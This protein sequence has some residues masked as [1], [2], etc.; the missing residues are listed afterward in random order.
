MSNSDPPGRHYIM[1]GVEFTA[2]RPEP[3][4][5]VTATPIGHLGDVTLRALETLA[6]ADEILCEDTRVTAKLTSRY[7][8]RTPLR[9]YHDHNAAKLRPHIIERLKEGAAIAL[10]SDAGTPLVSDPGYKLIAAVIA[11]GLP[12]HVLPGA[13]APL[14]GLLQS[15]LPP[16][17]FMFLGFLPEKQGER[18]RRL[19][20]LKSADATLIVFESPHRIAGTLAD[21][22]AIMGTRAVAV[23]REL[24]KLHEEILRGPAADIGA[25][26]A[27]REAVKGEITLVI[28]PP[29]EEAAPDPAMVDRELIAAASELSPS[30]AASLVARRTGLAKKDLYARLLALKRES[31]P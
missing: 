23:T 10:V 6:G 27:A 18:R 9:P 11:E 20:A 17:R 22:A 24:T 12:L 21:I 15:G 31:R 5:H 29:T 25:K 28:A 3:G 7:G 16:D 26:L 19:E 8:I 2:D 1:K 14:T 30:A 4:L 13:S